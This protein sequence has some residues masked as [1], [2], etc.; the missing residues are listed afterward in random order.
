MNGDNS[1]QKKKLG[2]LGI[3]YIEGSSD[4]TARNLKK[5]NIFIYYKPDKTTNHK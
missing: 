5:N 3:P 4:Q 1:D 2:Y